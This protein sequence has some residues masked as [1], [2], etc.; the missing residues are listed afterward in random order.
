[1]DK[2]IKQRLF[3][4]MNRVGGMPIVNEADSLPPGITNNDII[5]LD[6]FVD[7][8]NIQEDT[9]GV[10]MQ[11]A[12][13]KKIVDKRKSGTPRDREDPY[14]HS[15]TIEIINRN[16]NEIDQEQLKKIITQRPPTLL[17]S[18]EKVGKTGILKISLPAYKGLYYDE[19][20]RQF[21]VV[22]TC[23]NA[24]ECK[25]YCYQ[26]KGRS[27]MFDNAAI[28]KTRI[29][30]F[31]LNHWDAFKYKM[32]DEIETAKMGNDKK[33][34][35]TI[36]R[37]HDSGDFI[38]DKYL[39]LAMDIARETPDVL[40]YAYTKMV[41]SAKRANVPSNFV[42][43]YSL[44]VG[45]PETGLVNKYEDKHTEVVPKQLFKDLVHSKKEPI[46]GGK[47]FKNVWQY[48]SKHDLDELK[49]R[50]SKQYG[51]DINTII[52]FGEMQK[53]PKQGE[54]K[55]NVIVTPSD[56]DTAAHR[57]DVLGVY[58]LIH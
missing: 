58:L 52:T 16:G 1:M 48:N 15:K 7:S 45:S 32:V 56:P 11:P 25:L 30:N 44:D 24:G 21:K 23:P 10:Q 39:D 53:I 43:R 46:K 28:S 40:H 41:S 20:D 12:D 51:I 50:L 54:N 8:G 57:K 37:W 35:K 13:I 26:Q 31:L 19:K 14:I 17:S 22:N 27:V 3:E 55:W 29:L 9:T 2:N 33:G 47:E 49:N 38:S 5:S 36:V 42:F 4:M 18:N 34:L 6:D